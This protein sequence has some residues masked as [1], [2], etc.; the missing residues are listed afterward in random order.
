MDAKAG[1]T[2]EEPFCIGV[3]IIG[4]VVVGLDGIGGIG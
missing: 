4:L 1:G 2:G 3:E